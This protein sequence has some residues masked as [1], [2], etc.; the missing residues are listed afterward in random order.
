MSHDRH[1]AIA[2]FDLDKTITRCDTYRVFLRHVLWRHPGRW[3]R[4]PWLLLATLLFLARRRDN[5]WLKG[6]FLRH[7]VGGASRAR[8]RRWIDATVAELLADWLKPAALREL[9]RHQQEGRPVILATASL[10]LYVMPLAAGLGIDTVVCTRTDWSE[11]GV[12]QAAFA[13]RLT[14]PNCLA[15]N[16][17]VAL[18][19]HLGREL[20][21]CQA[22]VYSDHQA[23]VS[24]LS[25]AAHPVAVDPTPTLARI[26]RERG[27]SIVDWR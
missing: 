25:A 16:K 9:K 10:D 20:A 13:G 17:L 2:V 14:S 12:E 21:D 6:E 1:Q 4:L 5:G 15:G 27:W 11:P 26:A 22:F 3:G 23:D 8:V 18:E 19:R 7:L 24:I